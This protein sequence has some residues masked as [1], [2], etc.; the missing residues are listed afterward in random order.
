LA[1]FNENDFLGRVNDCLADLDSGG[2]G[3]EERG[4][5][6]AIALHAELELRRFVCHIRDEN[7]YCPVCK[8]LKDGV[9]HGAGE[10]RRCDDCDAKQKELK[11]AAGL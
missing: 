10:A 6:T 3:V 11:K 1:N 2:R 5:E 8:K 4:R 7:S 9:V